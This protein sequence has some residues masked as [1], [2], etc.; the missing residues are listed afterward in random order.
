MGKCVGCETTYH[1][2]A[3]AILRRRQV[4]DRFSVEPVGGRTESIIVTAF[5]TTGNTSVNRG[6]EN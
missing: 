3:V 4:I 5:T 6:I 2:T 1:M